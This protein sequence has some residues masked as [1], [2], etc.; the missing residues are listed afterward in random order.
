MLDV[1]LICFADLLGFIPGLKAAQKIVEQSGGK[2]V[3]GVTG[4]ATIGLCPTPTGAVTVYKAEICLGGFIEVGA[5][6]ERR[7]SLMAFS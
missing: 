7:R 3:A 5:G 1:E 4:S 6:L 2:I